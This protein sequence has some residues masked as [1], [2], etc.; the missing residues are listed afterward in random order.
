MATPNIP[1]SNGSKVTTRT[2]DWT[3]M[4]LQQW[5]AEWNKPDTAYIF[6]DGR[7]FDCTDQYTSGIYRRS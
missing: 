1:Q 3:Q 7:R 4:V 2:L 5:G 6:N